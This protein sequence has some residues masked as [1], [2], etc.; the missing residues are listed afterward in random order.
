MLLRRVHAACMQIKTHDLYCWAVSCLMNVLYRGSKSRPT[1]V[2]AAKY[3]NNSQIVREEMNSVSRAHDGRPTVA[4]A[5]NGSALLGGGNR[6]G[7][8]PVAVIKELLYTPSP[9]TLRVGLCPRPPGSVA[10]AWNRCGTPRDVSPHF[11]RDW[12]RAPPTAA[13]SLSPRSE[14]EREWFHVVVQIDAV[15]H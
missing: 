6:G 8:Q 10:E 13:G 5:H 9:A 14:R 7:G 11:I 2:C 15:G 3:H 12:P 1:A 4:P